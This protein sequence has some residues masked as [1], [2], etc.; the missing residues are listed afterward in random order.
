MSVSREKFADWELKGNPRGMSFSNKGCVSWSSLI[1][2][3][4][5][6]APSF[7]CYATGGSMIGTA[8]MPVRRARVEPEAA[9]ASSPTIP[10]TKGTGGTVSETKKAEVTKDEEVPQGRPRVNLHNLCSGTPL[11]FGGYPGRGAQGCLHIGSAERVPQDQAHR[12]D[13]QL[14]QDRGTRPA[15]CLS[16][17]S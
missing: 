17:E 1:P 14:W 8:S 5:N 2:P 3:R 9:V 15:E 16:L 12:Q 7:S 4:H 13:H 10:P 6:T 11:V